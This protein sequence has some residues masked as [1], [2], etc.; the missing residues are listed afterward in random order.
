MNHIDSIQFMTDDGE[1]ISVFIAEAIH[2]IDEE[3]AV[4]LQLPVFADG[5]SGVMYLTQQEV[6]LLRKSPVI[7]G[8]TAW[9]LNSRLANFK[10]RIPKKN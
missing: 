8:A 7:K 2:E 10:P 9:A 5:R 1:S 3:G 6:A 4:I